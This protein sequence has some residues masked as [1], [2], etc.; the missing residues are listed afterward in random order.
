MKNSIIVSSLSALALLCSCVP[1]HRDFNMPDS[2]VYFTDNTANKGVQHVLIYDVQTE[3][4]TPVYVHCAG[5]QAGT[6]NVKAHVAED[7]IDY[8]NKVN[9]TAYKALPENCYTL[10]K[11][12]DALSGRTASFA[13]SFNVPNIIEFSKEDGVDINDYV[14]A[15][16]LDA[17]NLPVATVKDTISLGFYMVS[18][19]LRNATL[20]IK[21]TGL[22]PDGNMTITAEL[23]FENSWDLTYDVE[24][25]TPDVD[26][27]STDKGNR[28]PAKY[29]YADSFPEGTVIGN[30]DVK[31]MAP[32]TNKVEYDITIPAEGLVWAPGKAFNYAVRFSNAVLNG[33]EIPID[34]PLLTASLNVGVDIKAAN[35][36]TQLGTRLAEYGL[37]PLDDK[38]G[39]GR[40]GDFLENIVPGGGFIFHPQTSQDKRPLADYSVSGVFDDRVSNTAHSWMQNWGWNGDNGYGATSFSTPY[41]LLVDMQEEFNMGGVEYWTRSDGRY[42][43]KAVEIYALDDC[44][45]TLNQSVLN[46][47]EEDVTYIGC[48]RFTTGAQSVSVSVDPV[49]TRY[50][51]LLITEASGGLDCQ[52]M[53][54]WGY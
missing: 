28:I 31:S 34:N 22:T 41:W 19:I 46:Y 9:F 35:S 15:L 29:V 25:A 8:Y 38:Q 18:P 36:N 40:S 26:V 7:Y 1:D 4:E 33:K 49:R 50:I 44:S 53:V 17:D 39:G 54:L 32:G 11:S 12:A 5:L 37:T 47:K 27:L 42:N 6:S 20:K 13:V 16:G 23:P 24:F 43:M 45:Y 51:M 21:S 2:S 30:G 52:E 10:T 3:V 14:L 48:L